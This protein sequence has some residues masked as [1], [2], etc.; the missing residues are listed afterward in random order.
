MESLAVH[1][2]KRV[3][4]GAVMALAHAALVKTEPPRRVIPAQVRFWFNEE[5]ENA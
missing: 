3:M 2:L 4:V 5:I 1:T